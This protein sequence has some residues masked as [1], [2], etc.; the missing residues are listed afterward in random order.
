MS[1]KSKGCQKPKELKGKPQGC[2]PEQVRKCH[3]DVAVHPCLAKKDARKR[4][5]R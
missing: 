2:S 3:G 4:G 1:A 5:A